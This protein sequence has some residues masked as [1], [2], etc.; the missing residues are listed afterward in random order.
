[1]GAAEPVRSGSRGS[2]RT[3]GTRGPG[4]RPLAEE[5]TATVLDLHGEG[6]E[7]LVEALDE[8]TRG[9]SRTTAWWAAC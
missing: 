6:L 7:R 9:R 2:R 3:R 1:M 5:L 4:V 8:D